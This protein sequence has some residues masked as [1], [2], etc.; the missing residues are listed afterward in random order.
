MGFAVAEGP[1][2]ENDFHNFAALNFPPEHPAR[3]MQDTFYVGPSGRRAAGAAHPHQPGADPHDAGRAAAG[4][5][6][7]PGR[8]YRIDNDLRHSPMFHQV[9]GLVIDRGI[10]FGHLK[11]AS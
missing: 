1:E 4:P 11:G 3:Q 6:H 8:V 5:R 7:R 10:P 2:I 9:E